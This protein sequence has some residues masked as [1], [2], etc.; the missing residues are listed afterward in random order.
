MLDLVNKFIEKGFTVK[1]LRANEKLPICQDKKL[2]AKGT[3]KISNKNS[4]KILKEDPKLNYGVL[5]GDDVIIVDIDLK[6]SKPDKKTGQIAITAEEARRRW[7]TLQDEIGTDFLNTLTQESTTGGLHLF[8]KLDDESRKITQTTKF[9]DYID[10]RR[11]TGYVVGAGSKIDGKEYKLTKDIDMLVCPKEL[12]E[13]LLYYKHKKLPVIEKKPQKPLK[14]DP[15]YEI[16][17][18]PEVNKELEWVILKRFFDECYKEDRFTDYDDWIKIG[19]GIKNRYGENGFELWEYYSNKSKNPD[20]KAKLTV[21][22]NGFKTDKER[23][24][25]IGTLYLYAKT[26]N[27]EKYKQILDEVY[28]EINEV[29]SHETFNMEYFG[30]LMLENDKGKFIYTKKQKTYFEQYVCAVENPSRFYVKEGNIMSPREFLLN[31]PE[32]PGFIKCWLTDTKKK[33]YKRVDFRPDIENCPADVLNLF[34]G[35]DVVNNY[36]EYDKSKRDEI[37]KPLLDH[38]SMLFNHDEKFLNYYYKYHANMFQN[39]EKKAGTALIMRGE[40]GAGKNFTVTDIWGHMIGQHSYISDNKPDTFFNTHSVVLENKMLVNVDEVRGKDTSDVIEQIKGWITNPETHINGKG[41]K[42]IG[43]KLFAYFVFTTNNKTPVQI[44]QGERRF[45]VVDTSSEKLNDVKYFSAL[46]KLITK[47][48]VMMSAFYDYLMSIEIPE[49]F[50][51]ANERPINEAYKDIQSAFIP[52]HIQFLVETI[53]TLFVKKD[54]NNYVAEVEEIDISAK[55]FLDQYLLWRREGNFKD[56]N[57]NSTQYGRLMND[58]R[59][60]TNY[61]KGVKYYNLNKAE[62]EAYLKNKKYI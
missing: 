54:K 31:F 4:L 24:I 41:I 17:E 45:W 46:K 20:P 59:G 52:S 18:D 40:Q 44:P 22:F 19:M 14:E 35:F 10:T 56:D 42:A 32:F 15:K 49:D 33:C 55:D 50:E 27:L 11:N 3:E 7:Q 21:M 34:K 8:Y 58:V 43:I 2:F 28:A 1:P 53:D 38:F 62:I 36:V 5:A 6:D 26:D 60:I 12:T 25:N 37:I 9:D 39:P 13:K 23:Q 48:W 30:S 57:M 16:K 47:D 29:E 61:K 51:W